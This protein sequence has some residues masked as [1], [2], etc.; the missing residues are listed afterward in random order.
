LSAILGKIFLYV[1]RDELQKQQNGLPEIAHQLVSLPHTVG[2]GG[3]ESLETL[4]NSS[5]KILYFTAFQQG[6]VLTAKRDR[7]YLRACLPV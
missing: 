5:T 1:T 3:T 2:A 7:N 6:K 4:L